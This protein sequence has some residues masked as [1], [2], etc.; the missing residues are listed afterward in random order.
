MAGGT[1]QK[2]PKCGSLAVGW[3]I[4]RSGKILRQGWRIRHTPSCSCLDHVFRHYILAP[5]CNYVNFNVSRLRGFHLF[6]PWTMSFHGEIS[7]VRKG[8][9]RRRRRRMPRILLSA[10]PTFLP[11]LLQ[12]NYIFAAPLPFPHFS[13]ML[14]FSIVPDRVGVKD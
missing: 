5:I 11:S 2:S 12:I 1:N 9:R 4:P 6:S 14:T 8:R 7:F 3:M 10:I 13:A